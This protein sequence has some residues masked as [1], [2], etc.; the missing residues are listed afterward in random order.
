MR[1][2]LVFVRRGHVRIPLTFAF[3]IPEHYSPQTARRQTEGSPRQDAPRSLSIKSAMLS[4]QALSLDH[5]ADHRLADAALLPPTEQT[6]LN[7]TVDIT[8]PRF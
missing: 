5:R 6:P 3:H 8:Q 4:A 1:Q 2:L 7:G